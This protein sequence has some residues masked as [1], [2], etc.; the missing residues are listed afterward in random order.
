MWKNYEKGVRNY[1]GITFPDGLLK[2][3]KLKENVLT[4]T[5]K[6]E[7]DRPISPEEIVAE[8]WMTR[9]D[10]EYCKRAALELFSFGILCL[11]LKKKRIDGL[12]CVGQKVA[13]EHGLILVDTKYEFGR[14]KDGNILVIDEMHTPDSSR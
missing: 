8:K 6:E 14:D 9:E 12:I 1:C 7:N 2:N 13:K 10:F 11:Y 4:P 5:T 3:Q